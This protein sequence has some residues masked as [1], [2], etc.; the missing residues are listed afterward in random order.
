[1]LIFAMISS[2]SVTEMSKHDH[3]HLHEN[4]LKNLYATFIAQWSKD[5]KK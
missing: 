3:D 2:S 1:M 4:P 5:K